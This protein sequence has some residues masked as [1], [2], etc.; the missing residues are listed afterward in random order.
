[1]K[2]NDEKIAEQDLI[3]EINILL[4]AMLLYAGVRRERLADAA[5]LY[6]ENIDTVLANSDA[7]GADEVIAVVEFLRDKHAELFENK[8]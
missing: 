5:Q 1:M 4:D 8:G 2:N 3:Y 7:S 6:I